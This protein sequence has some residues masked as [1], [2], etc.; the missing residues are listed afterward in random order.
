MGT[1]YKNP[2]GWQS[3]ATALPVPVVQEGQNPGTAYMVDGFIFGIMTY[4]IEI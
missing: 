2:Q 4:V 1:V 3:T